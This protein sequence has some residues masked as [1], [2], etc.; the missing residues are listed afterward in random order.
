MQLTLRKALGADVCWPAFNEE[1]TNCLKSNALYLTEFISVHQSAVEKNV[2][3][4]SITWLGLNTH[5]YLF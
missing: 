5:S 3:V 4:P 1:A 2:V